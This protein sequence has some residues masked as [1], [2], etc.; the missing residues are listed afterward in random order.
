MD[1]GTTTKYLLVALQERLLSQTAVPDILWTDKG[2]H[3]MGKWSH[4]QDSANLPDNN[5]KAEAAVYEKII[6]LV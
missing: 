3:F 6:C 4:L 1:K 2:C 5:G